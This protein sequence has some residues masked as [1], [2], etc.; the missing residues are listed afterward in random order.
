M[1]RVWGSKPFVDFKLPADEV[2]IFLKK[3]NALL[4]KYLTEPLSE[5]NAQNF[6][7]LLIVLKAH[8]KA[9]KVYSLAQYE[10]F[11]EIQTILKYLPEKISHWHP[12][13]PSEDQP[14]DIADYI[15]T[16]CKLIYRAIRLENSENATNFARTKALE[17]FLLIL[18]SVVHR[19]NVGNSMETYNYYEDM[20][21]SYEDL[22]I[23]D[24]II[25][26]IVK[27]LQKCYPELASL[28]PESK[29]Q[30]FMNLR[31]VSK[32]PLIL[33]EYV[34]TYNIRT[35]SYKD[36][37]RTKSS[38]LE[39][40]PIHK[41]LSAITEGDNEG[42]VIET[43]S[44]V[45]TSVFNLISSQPDTSEADVCIMKIFIITKNLLDLLV[46]CSIDVHYITTFIQAGLAW[47][48]LEFLTY[49]NDIGQVSEATHNPHL[50]TMFINIEKICNIFRNIVM[51]SNE[52][53]IWKLAGASENIN[54]VEIIVSSKESSSEV[55]RALT[56]LNADSKFLLCQF[57]ECTL[58]LLGK[59]LVQILLADYTQPRTTPKEKDIISINRFLRIFSTELSEPTE[60]WN[61]ETRIE[62]KTL[63][64][65]QISRINDTNGK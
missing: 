43:Y 8:K 60:L 49:Y 40:L 61:E 45:T 7:E 19:I 38:Y 47:R 30:L 41:A 35:K 58:Q 36:I 21:I 31:T 59:R 13:E 12:I 33:F 6:T 57:F 50:Q 22:K 42:S 26:I 18:D 10:C 56:K 20:Q 2:P 52:A 25:R 24:L 17:V 1:L 15:L 27:M 54:D 5:S 64:I 44:P 3:L 4:K 51:Y 53:Y 37:D 46:E 34:R 63:L 65:E 9:I 55:S 28:S 14:L 32:I 48:F 29:I 62:L 16:L 23:L 11:G 39:R